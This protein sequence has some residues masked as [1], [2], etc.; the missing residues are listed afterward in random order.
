MVE[1]VKQND[2]PGRIKD[3]DGLYKALFKLRK[4]NEEQ[5]HDDEQRSKE[6]AETNA[7]YQPATKSRNY[8]IQ[9]LKEA[10]ED[11]YL[12][13]GDS[14]KYKSRN[15]SVSKR[16]STVWKHDDSELL[17]AVP[18]EFIK[19]SVEWGKYKKTLKATPDGRAVNEDGELVPG[20]T[21]EQSFKVSIT[22]PKE[23]G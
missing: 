22:L 15:G 4:L 10:I 5:A 8:E 7:W 18:E 12:R 13:Q 16:K 3:E 14:Y 19:R 21:T 6:L 20:V 11:F 23:E 2:L 17:N 9:S 1:A